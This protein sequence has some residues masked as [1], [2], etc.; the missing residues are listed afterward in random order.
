MGALAIEPSR[1]EHD[2]VWA[3]GSV[4]ATVSALAARGGTVTWLSIRGAGQESPPG[5][6]PVGG[7]LLASSA[8][9]RVLVCAPDPGQA[10]ALGDPF[11]AALADAQRVARCAPAPDAV[12]HDVL[13]APGADTVVVA[14]GPDGG[15]CAELP[16]P[17]LNGLVQLLVDALWDAAL[18]LASAEH[19]ERVTRDPVKLKI[20]G[21]LESGAKD[22][23]IARALGVSL[24]T[25]RR[26]IA[27]I[28]AT[29]GAVNRFQAAVRFA[30]AG[31]LGAA[32]C[33][34]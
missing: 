17:A 18:P 32:P 19:F 29:A 13:T 7:P 34:E 20:L 6:D 5:T 3:P 4:Q 2:R 24:R 12:R 33:A 30:R 8:P 9:L 1:G 21:L 15:L 14:P 16:G 28:L 25:C 10:R 11:R 27:E 23:A 22:E 26:H 31:V